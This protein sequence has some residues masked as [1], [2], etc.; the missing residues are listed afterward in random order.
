[1]KEIIVEEIVAKTAFSKPVFLDDGYILL[2][3]YIQFTDELRKRLLKWNF[4]AV[5]TDGDPIEPTLGAGAV[6]EEDGGQPAAA[7]SLEDEEQKNQAAAFFQTLVDFLENSFERFKSKEELRI[8]DFTEKAKNVMTELKDNKRFILNIDDSISSEKS[9]V[10][11]HSAKTAM[12][13]LL[14]ADYLKLPSFKQVDVG[15]AALLHEIG[16]M[17]IPE[18]IYLSN[19]AL[20]PQEKKTLAAHPVIGFRILKGAGFPD[21]VCLA[22]LEQNERLDGSGMPRQLKG[23]KI[24]TLGRILAVATSFSAA[25]SNRPYRQAIDGH[26]GLVDLLKDAG[27]RYDD[28]ALAAL[29]LTLSLYP[30]GTHVKMSNGSIGI[31]VKENPDNP[32]FPAV[33]LL[34]DGK[35]SPYADQPVVQT[36]EGDEVFITGSIR[37]DEI[38]QLNISGTSN[39]DL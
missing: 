38:A 35:G 31:V 6:D 25:T 3:P 11:I 4:T 5:F 12:L 8:L 18:S 34:I 26:A 19:R 33:K 20:N 39:N 15:T 13:S 9:Y 22:V 27:K 10:L 32:R 23:D 7:R 14:I 1:M 36:R 2:S 30:L 16:L 21:T 24:S 28:K 29:V 37:K 17:K